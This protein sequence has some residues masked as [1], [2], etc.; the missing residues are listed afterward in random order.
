MGTTLSGLRRQQSLSSLKALRTL[1]AL[2]PLRVASRLQGMKVVV[3]SLFASLP[4]LGNVL[5]VCLLFYL[6]FGIMAVD[7]LGVSGSLQEV[8]GM[9]TAWSTMS[10]S[11]V[12]P[13]DWCSMYLARTAVSFIFD[14]CSTG[15]VKQSCRVA[16][17][18]LPCVCQARCMAYI[19][20]RYCLSPGGAP[21]AG[22]IVRLSGPFWT[23]V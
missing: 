21:V 1:R 22:I 14:V 4:A 16:P 11:T 6:I 3:N 23:A 17:I 9:A 20:V 7:L 10:R 2:R 5:L 13:L 15:S 19:D 18:G 12:V 8:S